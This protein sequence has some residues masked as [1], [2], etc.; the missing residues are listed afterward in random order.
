[1]YVY[2]ENKITSYGG[3]DYPPMDNNMTFFKGQGSFLLFI[4]NIEDREELCSK[5]SYIYRLDSVVRVLLHLLLHLRTFEP[6]V[7]GIRMFRLQRETFSEQAVGLTVT[8][9]VATVNHFA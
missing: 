3:L 1:M 5:C 7:S 4:K 6:L 8:C 9:R 2:T